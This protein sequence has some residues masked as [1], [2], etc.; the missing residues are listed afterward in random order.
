MHY[1][2]TFIALVVT[3]FLLPAYGRVEELDLYAWR[4]GEP[5]PKGWSA[6][7]LNK[8]AEGKDMYGGAYF[9]AKT[10]WL[11]SPVFE[12]AIRSVTI[13]VSTSTPDPTRLMYLQPMRGGAAVSERIP[14]EK[15]PTR[16]YVQ[17]IFEIDGFGADQ[18]EL[19]LDGSGSDG[20]W[21]IVY[22][23]VR[24]GT[25]EAGEKGD[26]P[27]C[28]WALSSFAPKPGIRRADF[29]PLGGIIPGASSNLWQ[30]GETVRGFH[31]FFGDEPCANIR[32]GSPTSTAGGLYM[33]VTN[34][35][36]GSLRALALR[37]TGKQTA[38]LILPIELDASRRL[39]RMSVSYRIWE[40]RKE[41]R[42]SSL[43]FAWRTAN[44]LEPLDVTGTSW[45]AFESADWESGETNASR[46]VELPERALRTAEYV[47]LRWQVPQQT[48]SSIVG[49]S[50]VSVAAAFYPSG[51]KILI[52]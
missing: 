34:D 24:Y 49:I 23:I 39:E 15:T 31:A 33:V 16:E 6:D 47:C 12:S 29:S 44:D 26:G 51:F 2:N 22:I 5:L 21:A 40:L 13:Y 48:D 10:G 37:G 36:R 45:N 8:A 14:V 7:K 9:N 46:T 19:N 35:V 17:Q 32:N 1:Q 41:G 3:V 43:S 28:F 52:R 18:F 30:N 25:P 38:S 20:N 4:G 50:D 42:S 11:R 27:S